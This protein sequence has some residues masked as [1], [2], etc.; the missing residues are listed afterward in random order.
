MVEESSAS[1]E[2]ISQMVKH[3]VD[4]A[5]K[6]NNYALETSKVAENSSI[7]VDRAI[8]EIEGIK[9]AS[10]KIDQIIQVID[11]IAF[12]TNLLALNAAVEASRAGEAGKGFSVVAEE[13]RNLAQRSALASKEIKSVIHNS[14]QQIDNG[15]ESVNESKDAF[16]NIL[17][18]VKEVA[19]LIEQIAHSSRN[20]SISIEEINVAVRLMD[21]MTQENVVL[22]QNTNIMSGSLKDLS[23]ELV[24]NISFFQK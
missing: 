24:E 20:Q 18:S 21:N 7:I 14:N 8:Q 12:Q 5:S 15:V 10:K 13:V 17:H 6:A 23:Q 3:S 1:L 4:H 22:V 16:K 2:Q 11:E 19:I 9:N